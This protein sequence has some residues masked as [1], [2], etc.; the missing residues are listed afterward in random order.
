MLSIAGNFFSSRD[1]GMSTPA[2]SPC[3]L[4]SLANCGTSSPRS[5]GFGIGRAGPEHAH[6]PSCI[7]K[8]LQPVCVR[9]GLR[10]EGFE[11]CWNQQV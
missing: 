4:P 9:G 6:E 5:G 3:H 7:L 1:A 11:S 8:A 2:M 10:F